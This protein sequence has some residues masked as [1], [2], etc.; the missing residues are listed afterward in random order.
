MATTIS[1]NILSKCSTAQSVDTSRVD[2]LTMANIPVTTPSDLAT[3]YRS[4]SDFRIIGDL[5]SAELKGKTCQAK[6]NGVSDWLK[7]TTRI[8]DGKRL[9]NEY[10]SSK[11]YRTRPFIL[12]DVEDPIQNQYW[13]VTGGTAVD[14]QGAPLNGSPSGEPSAA[15][16]A[17]AYAAGARYF[18]Y[19][20]TQTDIPADVRWFNSRAR[21][22]ITGKGTSGQKVV[23]P[24]QVVSGTFNSTAYPN[25]GS[26][27]IR[28]FLKPLWAG[29]SSDG[30]NSKREHVSE[31]VLV[32]GLPNVTPGES[33]YEDTPGLN[34]TR[35]HEFWVQWSR[36]TS[37]VD[38]EYQMFAKMI[39]ENNPLY[40]KFGDVD[41]VKW[42]RQ[43]AEDHDMRMAQSFFENPRLANQT[44]TSW[45]S[46][47]KTQFYSGDA[48]SHAFHWEGRYD[49]Y[50]A[51][52]LGYVDLLAECASA[53]PR[54]W[55]K[56]GAK[57]NLDE[58]HAE[59]YKMLRIRKANGLPG[60]VI[61]VWTTSS[62]REQMI[63][64]YLRYFKGKSEGMLS[65]NK[66]LVSTTGGNDLGFQWKDIVLD[67]PAVTLRF[68]SHDWFDDYVNAHT[69]AAGDASLSDVNT[70]ALSN[71]ANML[72]IPDW[73]NA[74]RLVLETR[75][76]VRE[77]GSAEEIA[78]IDPSLLY[79][80]LDVPK[81]K[82]E[83]VSTLYTN[84]LEC[85][86]SHLVIE[87]FDPGVPTSEW[88]TGA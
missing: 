47:E 25:V 21:V 53:D 14:D 45:G 67:W 73:S 57:I 88:I 81:L 37:R 16:G 39:A 46:L 72:M 64:A 76:D 59:L 31:G 85:P 43:R 65:L 23:A 54:I 33:Y 35:S 63:Q 62:Y 68:V 75:K 50:R 1:S 74:Y 61:E 19:I 13:S 36:T 70:A 66:D 30:L 48:T 34:S 17:A 42:N 4:G 44:L 58:F 28:C 12:M 82:V 41:A 86:G 80:P 38:S 24:Y 78:K 87:N 71:T 52:A 26:G 10:V 27:K 20:E 77:T 40:K 49:Q 11:R 69:V 32:R 79:G 84:I 9:N 15:A 55:D 56:A 8:G 5:L 60:K 29:D 6:Q 7:A 83:H 2:G 22:T 3:I 18:C 51:N